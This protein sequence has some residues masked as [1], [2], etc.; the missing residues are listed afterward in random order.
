MIPQQAQQA[1]FARRG[2]K[3]V[4]ELKSVWAGGTAG[5]THEQRKS[6]PIDPEKEGCNPGNGAC[7]EDN[8]VPH[9]S[10]TLGGPRTVDSQT[11]VLGRT[12][13]ARGASA[14]LQ[15]TRVLSIHRPQGRLARALRATRV[16]G[17]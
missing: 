4:E 11:D 17:L 8:G 16:T 6:A 9:G 2:K 15:E 10:R 3:N 5:S 12:R 1:G 14:G 7:N 13:P